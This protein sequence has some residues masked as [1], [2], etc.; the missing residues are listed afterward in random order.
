[1][2]GV[3][4]R[5]PD[6]ND[7]VVIKS[8][9][10]VEDFCLRIHKSF[11]KQFK[12]ALVW[13]SSVKHR[14]QKVMRRCSC[15]AALRLFGHRF[16]VI[17]QPALRRLLTCVSYIQQVG[18]KHPLEDEDVVQIVLKVRT[19]SHGL[20]ACFECMMCTLAAQHTQG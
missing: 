6:Y 7:P 10:T 2:A 4:G 8:G 12:H 20:L 13:G 5:V 19:V 17:L 15:P 14:P 3:Q 9:S 16:M 1:M 11:V 18:L